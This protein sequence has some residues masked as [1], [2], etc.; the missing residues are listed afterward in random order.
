MNKAN[1]P[2]WLAKLARTDNFI[3]VTDKEYGLRLDISMLGVGGVDSVTHQR[4]ALAS[5]RET[6]DEVIKEFDEQVSNMIGNEFIKVKKPVPKK[7]PGSKVKK[8][9]VK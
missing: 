3:I 5:I 2:Y 1:K 4:A 6:L 7:K 8:I 9:T